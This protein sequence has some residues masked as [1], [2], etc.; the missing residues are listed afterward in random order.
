MVR[1]SDD[2]RLY[3]NV[4]GLEIPPDPNDPSVVQVYISF[5]ELSYC[6]PAQRFSGGQRLLIPPHVANDI[7]F[8]LSEDQPVFIRVGRYQ[9]DIYPDKFLEAYYRLICQ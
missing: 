5:K 3:I 6:F 7:I 2:V 1:M 9:A 4:Y 8:Y